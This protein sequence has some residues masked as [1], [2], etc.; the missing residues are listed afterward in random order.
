MTPI[1]ATVR[2]SCINLEFYIVNEIF[3]LNLML[4]AIYLP[5]ICHIFP[6]VL[7]CRPELRFLDLS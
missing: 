6:L 1:F 2:I 7:N 3:V 4:F 5:Y